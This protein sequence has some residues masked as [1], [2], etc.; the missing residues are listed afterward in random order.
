MPRAYFGFDAESVPGKHIFVSYSRGDA[1][2][3]SDL[4]LE[5]HKVG[6][7]IWYDDGL[8][9]GNR[10]ENEILENV[11]QS[12]ITV[13]FLTKN[14]F[15]RE[16]TFMLDEFQFANDYQKPTLC[17]WMDDIGNINCNSLS[18]DMYLWWKKIRSLQ[19]IEVFHLTSIKDITKE[20]CR[21]LCRA[22]SSF[23][24]LLKAVESKSEQNNPVDSKLS[25]SKSRELTNIMP[26]MNVRIGGMIQFGNYSLGV[27]GKVQPLFW[28]I[29]DIQNSNA[30]IICEKLIDYVNYH[31]SLI[32][33]TWED[34]TLRRW[35]NCDFFHIAFDS[36]EQSKI[37]YTVNHNSNN[38]KFGTKGGN[39]TQD[40]VFALSIEEAERYFS[41][42][43][44]R[45][46]Y[47]S[48]YAHSYDYDDFENDGRHAA[49]RCADG[50]RGPV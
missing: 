34:S 48:E 8:I 49:V 13:F 47:T 19:C 26:G 35:M 12:R 38:P 1:D 50:P 32:G 46:A 22:D 18:K 41:S 30:L 2:R 42:N 28:R 44:E 43:S 33:V 31:K 45:V 39:R 7:P 3:I 17:I 36:T 16:I 29:L 4:V 15:K 11:I 5:L 20:I 23:S 25:Q 24:D 14:L 21:G 27:Q 37:L 40:Y 9:P 10:W 6:L